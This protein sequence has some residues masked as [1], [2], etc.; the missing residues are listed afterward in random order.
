MADVP[1][2]LAPKSLRLDASIQF[3]GVRATKDGSG[4]VQFEMFGLEREQVGIIEILVPPRGSIDAIVA[5]GHRQL[6]DMLR[7]LVA[8]AESGREAYAK[9]AG[10]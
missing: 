9:M 8:E 3:R 2:H 7:H 5:E 10:R 4:I 1:D 6:V